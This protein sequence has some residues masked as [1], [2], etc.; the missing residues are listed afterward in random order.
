[1]VI[2]AIARV[3]RRLFALVVCFLAP[4][5]AELL[6][7]VARTA[8]AYGDGTAVLHKVEREAIAGAV[9]KR[10]EEFAGGRGCARNALAELG[11]RDPSIPMGPKGEPIWPPGIVGSITHCEGLRACAVARSSD[12]LSLGIDAEPNLALPSGVPIADIALPAEISRLDRAAKGDG[13]AIHWDRLL[14]CMKEAVFK[15]WFPLTKRWLGFEDAAIALDASRRSFRADVL[16][17]GATSDG[18]VI[19]SFFGRWAATDRFLAAAIAVP[20]VAPP[21]VWN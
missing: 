5:F 18:H 14:F 11:L 16:V 8:V 2:R 21:R 3:V 7:A 13:R 17:D 9:Q 20:L 6:P 1:M 12:L 19:S 15:A 10:R 4:M